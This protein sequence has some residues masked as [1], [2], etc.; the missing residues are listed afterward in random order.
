MKVLLVTSWDTPC[1]IA[2]HSAMLKE[3]VEASTYAISVVPSVEALD[4]LSLRVRMLLTDTHTTGRDT[5]IVH[6]NYQ[7]GLH[8]RWTPERIC[9]LRAAGYPVV[10]TYHDTGVPNSDQCKQVIAAANAA[11][12][13]EPYD[14][15]PPGTHYWRMGVPGWEKPQTAYLHDAR[16]VVGTVG[17]AFPWK[18]QSKLIEV[19]ASVGWTSLVIAPRA[20]REQIE[21]WLTI[22]P[23]MTVCADFVPRHEVISLLAGCDATAF[24]YVTHNTGQSGAI[25]IGLAARKPVIALKTCR[26]FRALHGDPLGSSAIR[27]CETFDDVRR[28]LINTTLQRADPWIVALA[29]QDSWEHLGEKYAALYR[30]LQ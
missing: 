3:A 15:L 16:P 14:D 12:V 8:S 27:W 13:H 28:E 10:V 17:F 22:D 18:C 26:Q 11:V 20:T 24:T 19:A 5:Q 1:G 29:E 2:E 21:E 9:E 23:E 25:C 7:A 30:S 6:L 4:P